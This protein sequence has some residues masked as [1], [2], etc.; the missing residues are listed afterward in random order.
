MSLDTLGLLAAQD[1]RAAASEVEVERSL[2]RS[3]TGRR[4]GRAVGAAMLVVA[5]VAAVVVG[6][7]ATHDLF[8]GEESAPPLDSGPAVTVGDRL[9]VP[10]ALTVPEGWDV[11]RDDRAVELRPLDRSDRSITLVGQPVMVFEP[12]DYQLRPLRE[13]LVVWTTTHP[14][15]DVSDQFGLDGPGFAWTGTEMTLSLKPD[16]TEIPLVPKPATD[17][18]LST[19][20]VKGADKTFLWDVIY[21]TDSPPLLVASRSSTPDDPVLKAGRDELLQSLVITTPAN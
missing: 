13:D 18:D 9:S 20:S 4:R 21:L 14:D 15:L 12:P 17:R 7:L 16:A 1:L 5:V 8:R 2:Q 19:L 3:L 11:R 6:W 10:V